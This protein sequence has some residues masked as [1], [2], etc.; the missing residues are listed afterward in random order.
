VTTVVV[1]K[2]NRTPDAADMFIDQNKRIRTLERNVS[3]MATASSYLTDEEPWPAEG[4]NGD[5]AAAVGAIWF[6]T[7]DSTANRWSEAGTWDVVAA[8]PRQKSFWYLNA[9]FS[10]ANNANTDINA[11]VDDGDT[12]S[13]LIVMDSQQN[14]TVQRDGLYRIS[15]GITYPVNATGRRY[16]QVFT[17]TSSGAVIVGDWRGTSSTGVITPQVSRLVRLSAGDIFR[18][19]GFQDS[20]G[21]LSLLSGNNFS[22][23]Q[24]E[25]EGA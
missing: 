23:L 21:A 5:H 2:Y 14:V 22:Y 9:G 6:N 17:G 16:V 10:I 15:V 25:Y 13:Y 1:N 20:G 4:P 24:V 7:S 12:N 8:W 19:T 11:W 3:S 18:V